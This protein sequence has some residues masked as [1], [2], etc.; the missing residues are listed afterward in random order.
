MWWHTGHDNS[1][2]KCTWALEFMYLTCIILIFLDVID[3]S[4]LEFFYTTTPPKEEAGMLFIG[5]AA[6]SSIIIPP[7]ADNFVIKS[8]CSADCLSQV[9]QPKKLVDMYC[10]CGCKINNYLPLSHSIYLKVESQYLQAFFTPTYLVRGM[11]PFSQVWCQESCV[12]HLLFRTWDNCTPF[13]QKRRLWGSR[14]T[15]TNRWKL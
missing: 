2:L 5:Y 10:V 11:L 6:A 1:H 9:R 13:Y 4:G 7:N 12:L 15:R 14:R 8:V 3:N